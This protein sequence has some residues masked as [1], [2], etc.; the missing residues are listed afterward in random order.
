MENY[1]QK[2]KKSQCTYTP[3]LHRRD[4]HFTFLPFIH[5]KYSLSWS[6]LHLLLCTLAY[7]RIA[8]L[9]LLCISHHHN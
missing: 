5:F 8:Q 4:F 9:I 6:L 1:L 2:F 7:H 3:S